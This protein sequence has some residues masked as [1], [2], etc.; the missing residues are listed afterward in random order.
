MENVTDKKMTIQMPPFLKLWKTNNKEQNSLLIGT[1]EPVQWVLDS[2]GNNSDIL[3][4]KLYV[5][6]VDYDKKGKMIISVG[7]IT[8]E[9]EYATCSVGGKDDQPTKNEREKYIKESKELIDC[10]WCVIRKSDFYYNCLAFAVDP[11]LQVFKNVIYDNGENIRP[12][13]NIDDRFPGSFRVNVVAITDKNHPIPLPSGNKD[14]FVLCTRIVIERGQ[15]VTIEDK[16]EEKFGHGNYL[17]TAVKTDSKYPYVELI[18]YTTSF[19][20]E[21]IN[22]LNSIPINLRYVQFQYFLLT[23][24]FSNCVDDGIDAFFESEIW[25]VNNGNQSFEKCTDVNDNNRKIVYYQKTHAARKASTLENNEYDMPNNMPGN[26]EVFAS[27]LG[28]SGVILHR[29][30][31]LV[32]G[33][34]PITR[35]YK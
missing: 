6:G 27:K 20:N 34:G 19:K 28:D 15:D 9:L 21:I 31:Q 26:W 29:A 17:L 7:G 3:N 16:A 13:M 11:Y 25:A 22:F 10:E 18:W 1:E 23:P 33:Y 5:E 12:L 24:Y 35:S 32:D 4:Q 30:E 14:N 2:Q 8:R